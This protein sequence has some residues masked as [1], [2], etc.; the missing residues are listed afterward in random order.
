MKGT[1]PNTPIY[2]APGTE[3][4]RPIMNMIWG[5][6]GRFERSIGILRMYTIVNIFFAHFSIM[7][8]IKFSTH[9]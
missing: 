9:S 3:H 7:I 5:D 2:Y 1:E 6:G 8:T 4:H